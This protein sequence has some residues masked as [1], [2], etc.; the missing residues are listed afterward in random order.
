MVYRGV[1]NRLS[2]I[3]KKS[4]ITKLQEEA[5][6]NQKKMFSLSHE[7]SFIA[8]RVTKLS[9]DPCGY[10]PEDSVFVAQRKAA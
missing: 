8:V 4:Q 2:F 9:C 10:D 6:M 7:S 1:K 3:V 5:S